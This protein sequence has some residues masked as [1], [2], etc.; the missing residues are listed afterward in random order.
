MAKRINTVDN[1]PSAEV[2]RIRNGTSFSELD[3]MPRT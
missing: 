2:P 1:K 3:S